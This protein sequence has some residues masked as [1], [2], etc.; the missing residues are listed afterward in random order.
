MGK[1]EERGANAVQMATGVALGGL[2][3]LGIELVVLL[4]G[5]AAVSNGI[6]KEDAAPQLTAAAC[7]LGCFGGGLLACAKW[8][9]RRLLGALAAG[10]VCYLLILAVGLLMSDELAFGLQSLI[11]LAGC[12]CGGALAGLL[13]GGRRKKRT[14]GRKK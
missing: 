10:A 3:A 12:L 8:K 2:L 4:L 1:A 9:S 5:A 11:E 13:G 7:V 6:L 14:S